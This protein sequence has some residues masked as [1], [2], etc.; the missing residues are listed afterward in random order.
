MTKKTYA[1]KGNVYKKEWEVNEELIEIL[2]K[3]TPI[4]ADKSYFE[5]VDWYVNHNRCICCDKEIV[6]NGH[7]NEENEKEY[8]ISGLCKECQTNAFRSEKGWEEHIEWMK[9]VGYIKGGDEDEGG[10][11]R[12]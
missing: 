1:S 8:K 2:K 3:A 12:S 6:K 7:W 5:D 9:E 10:N 11:D 4:K